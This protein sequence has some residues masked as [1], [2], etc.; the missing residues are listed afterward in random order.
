[1]IEQWEYKLLVAE[2]LPATFRDSEGVDYGRRL[3]QEL[4]N[5]LGSEGWEVC[6]YNASSTCS[7]VLILKRRLVPR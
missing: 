4:L 7:G 2:G 1:M 3:D 6:S 5:R